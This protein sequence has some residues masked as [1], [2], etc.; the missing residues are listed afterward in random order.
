MGMILE[1]TM[2]AASFL[3]FFT[4]TIHLLLRM[5]AK[6]DSS[7]FL[8][9]QALLKGQKEVMEANCGFQVDPLAV[10]A[11]ELKTIPAEFTSRRFFAAFTIDVVGIKFPL[12]RRK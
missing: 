11:V 5:P 8:E 6:A 10:L 1:D 4:I 9:V 7:R 2:K 3:A 12:A